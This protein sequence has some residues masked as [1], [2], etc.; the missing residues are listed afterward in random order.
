[1]DSPLSS[2]F[3]KNCIELLVA[4]PKKHSRHCFRSALRHLEKAEAL[5]GIDPAMAIFRGITAEEEAAS[6]LM[7]CLRE[8]DYVG[9]GHLKP[10]NHQHKHAVIPFLRILGLFFGQIFEKNV[11][12]YRLRI[13]EEDGQTRLMLAFPLSVGGEQKWAYPIPPFNF[14]VKVG[15]A[16]KPP[17]Y[18]SQISAFVDA[19]G[20]KNIRS[21]LKKVA[22]L[23]NEILYA[24]PDGYP[25]VTALK[26][27]FLHEKAS[28]VLI[29]LHTYLLISPYSDRQ[30]FVQDALGAFLTMVDA[31]EKSEEPAEG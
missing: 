6:G 4:T 16:A 20:A 17:S 8:L 11:K 31:L 14:A 2:Q 3:E 9:A 22:N 26:P 18:Q 12:E 30:P 5:S 21:Y 29:L 7:H 13:K 27:G 19:K 1:M 23:R 10:R 15:V 25:E 28:N 24:G